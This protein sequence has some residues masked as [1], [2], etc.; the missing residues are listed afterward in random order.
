[1]SPYFAD[2][3]ALVEYLRGSKS[4]APLIDDENWVTSLLNLTELYYAV[5]RDNDEKS[6]D[7]A[8]LAFR[9]RAVDVMDDDIKEG[10]KVRLRQRAKRVDLSYAD[11]IGYA[12]A[13]RRGAIFLTGDS[14]F[15]D[16]DGGDLVR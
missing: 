9:R 7:A 8:L 16:L 11:G 6:A 1:L 13:R 10:M 12:I 4:Y 15:A 3:Y 2:T 5:L 14:A